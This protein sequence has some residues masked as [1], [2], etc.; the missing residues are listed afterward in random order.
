[1][2]GVPVGRGYLNRPELTASRFVEDPFHPGERIYRTGDLGR[3]TADGMVEYL[4][5]E[6]GQL[7]IRGYRI[8]P[9]EVEYHLLQHPGVSGAVVEGRLGPAGSKE[10]VAWYI[11]AGPAADTDSLRAH[12]SRFLPDY[13]VP[14]RLVPVPDLPV[15]VNGK[16]DRKALPDPWAKQPASP[17]IAPR[18]DVE[19]A[20]LAIWQAVLGLDDVGND[21]S[22]FD[23]GGNSLLLIRLHLMIEERFPGAVKLTELFSVPTIGDQARLI[24]ERTTPLA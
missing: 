3:W 13:M 2:G 5:R 6:D 19:S 12:L 20:L 4:G 11:A 14:A 21:A 10:L 9:G 23:A 22:F 24:G 15:L 8:E 1:M 7:K 17:N 16:I 18:N